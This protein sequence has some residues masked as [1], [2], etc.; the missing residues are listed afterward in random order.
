MAAKKEKTM[1]RILLEVEESTDALDKEENIPFQSETTS[2]S[3]N[4]ASQ[5]RSTSYNYLAQSRF[6]QRAR[7][8]DKALIFVLQI[9][10]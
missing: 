8:K 5:T 9:I 2:L 7:S 1:V 3:G 4:L 10:I 6:G